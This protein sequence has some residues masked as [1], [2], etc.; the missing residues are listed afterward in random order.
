MELDYSV[1]SGPFLSFEIEIGDGPGPELDNWQNFRIDKYTNDQPRQN[2][3]TYTP[4]QIISEKCFMIQNIFCKQNHHLCVSFSIVAVL[5]VRSSGDTTWHLDW[6]GL[7][8]L[9]VVVAYTIHTHTLLG[10]VA[11]FCTIDI[12][13]RIHQPTT[14]LLCPII[15]G[16]QRLLLIFNHQQYQYLILL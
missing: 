1:S 11:W 12:F 13:W 8:S 4:I 7:M 14:S 3:Q 16:S 10:K 9:M 15:Y 2:W 6:L 5:C